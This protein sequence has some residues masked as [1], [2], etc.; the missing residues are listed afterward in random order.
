MQK[1][2]VMGYGMNIICLEPKIEANGSF[3]QSRQTNMH[4]CVCEVSEVAFL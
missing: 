1:I 3:Q 4:A 2:C